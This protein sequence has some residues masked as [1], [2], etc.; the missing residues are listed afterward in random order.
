MLLDIVVVHTGM[1]RKN[2]EKDANIIDTSRILK[3]LGVLQERVPSF[4]AALSS[5]W[6]LFGL[7]VILQEGLFQLGRLAAHQSY[8]LVRHWGTMAKVCEEALP[9]HASLQNW[10]ED[11]SD[12]LLP[13]LPIGTRML[14]S[15]VWRR[16][17]TMPELCQNDPGALVAARMVLAAGIHPA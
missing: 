5:G 15:R 8:T 10:L 11:E 17:A 4:E 3:T 6:P 14:A 1:L 2:M 16:L 13:R 12:E 7:L 9:L